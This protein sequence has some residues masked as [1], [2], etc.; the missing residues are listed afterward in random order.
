MIRSKQNWTLRKEDKETPKGVSETVPNDAWT[1]QEVLQRF[2]Q[3]LPLQTGTG[4]YL[5][6][7]EDADL[8]DLDV[9]EFDR[10]DLTEKAEIMEAVEERAEKAKATKKGT[11]KEP[12]KQEEKPP[13][14][15]AQK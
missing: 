8:D 3:G 13:E 14:N 12:E 9:M 1:I 2:T 5:E 10:M 15:T 11:K 4:V 7:S 6:G